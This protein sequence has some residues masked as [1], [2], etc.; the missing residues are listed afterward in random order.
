MAVSADGAINLTVNRLHITV[1]HYWSNRNHSNLSGLTAGIYTVYGNG[2]QRLLRT[3]T[4]IVPE[5]AVIIAA[6]M[7]F[8]L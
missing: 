3:Q 1:I 6:A 5:P 4:Y 2:W 8:I 7:V